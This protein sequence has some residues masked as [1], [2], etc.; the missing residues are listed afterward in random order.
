MNILQCVYN[1]ENKKLSENGICALEA[2]HYRKV[3][4]P[5]AVYVVDMNGYIGNSGS[6]KYHLPKHMKKISFFHS[7]YDLHGSEVIC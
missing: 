6:K 7:Q 3:E 2:A 4:H 1:T 5:D